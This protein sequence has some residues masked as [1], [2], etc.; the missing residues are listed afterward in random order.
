MKSQHLVTIPD[1]ELID[2]L[3]RAAT[4]ERDA[5]VDLLALLAEFDERKLYLG[6]GCASLFTYCTQV[7]HLSEHAAYHRIEGARVARGCP[8]VLELLSSGALTLTTAAPLRPVLTTENADAVLEAAVFKSKREVE[9]LVARLAPKPDVQ[10]M[11]RRIPSVEA[12]RLRFDAAPPANPSTTANERANAPVS[13]AVV[14]PR[15]LCTPLSPDR[16]L[17]ARDHIRARSS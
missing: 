17:L 9:L 14:Q 11:L 15:A 2:A 16:F 10:T 7:L 13:K 12:Q 8:R 1:R 4:N 6:E 5:T 3:Q